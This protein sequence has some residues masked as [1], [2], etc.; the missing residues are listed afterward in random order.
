MDLNFLSGIYVKN[1]LKKDNILV[2][3]DFG[4]QAQKVKGSRLK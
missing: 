3:V 4:S 2:K 1:P